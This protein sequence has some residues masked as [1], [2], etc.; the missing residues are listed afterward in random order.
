MRARIFAF[1]LTVLVAAES[2]SVKSDRSACPSLLFMSVSGGDDPGVSFRVGLDG[3][4][5]ESVHI[6]KVDGIAKAGF[7]LAK[8]EGYEVVS[9]NGVDQD[10]S[11][12]IELGEQMPSLYAYACRVDCLSDVEEIDVA[13]Q[14]QFCRVVIDV[15]GLECRVRLRSNVVGVVMES[16]AP[17]PGQFYV[18][19]S[20]LMY[21]E[22]S[23]ARYVISI[24]RQMDSSLS[25][26]LLPAQ[27]DDQAAFFTWNVGADLV[28]SGVD[29]SSPSLEDVYVNISYVENA[30]SVSVQNWEKVEL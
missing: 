17:V 4:C 30:F 24:P 28:E 19:A 3:E 16:L 22:K 27:G 15:I 12:E 20:P 23:G 1:F 25:L 29:W 8:A 5:R 13:L 6:S 14:K 26:E 11:G 21:S 7:D 2:C 9:F 18:V 10:W